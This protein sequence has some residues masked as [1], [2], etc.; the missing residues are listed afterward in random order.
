MTIL[1]EISRQNGKSTL[2]K[3]IAA[4][5]PRAK[6]LTQDIFKGHPKY[7]KWAV[8]D[9][10]GR[11]R[12]FINKPRLADA[13]S[14]LDQDIWVASHTAKKDTAEFKK[15]HR[16]GIIVG[17][18]FLCEIGTKYDYNIPLRREVA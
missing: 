5:D 9:T 6:D 14:N 12:L 17:E 15:K 13:Y 8:V 7:L 1:V 16:L 10:E 18:G 11:A 2:L 3:R 4:F